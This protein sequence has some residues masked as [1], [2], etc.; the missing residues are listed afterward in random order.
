MTFLSLNG[1]LAEIGRGVPEV[2][3]GLLSEREEDGSATVKLFDKIGGELLVERR[4]RFP[5]WA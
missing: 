5:A 3:Q 4:F 2:C 1:Q